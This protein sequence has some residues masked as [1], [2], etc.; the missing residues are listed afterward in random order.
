MLTKEMSLKTPQLQGNE[1]SLNI[2]LPTQAQATE[3]LPVVYLMDS[4][5]KN[6]KGGP[7]LGLFTKNL[8]QNFSGVFAQV[9]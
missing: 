2:L 7:Y 3:K 1:R 8:V 5:I 4:I 6:V 9:I